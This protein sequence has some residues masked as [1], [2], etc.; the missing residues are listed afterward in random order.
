MSVPKT[1]R[2]KASLARPAIARG[3][4]RAAHRLAIDVR[5]ATSMAICW[6]RRP[7]EGN[8]STRN[9]LLTLIVVLTTFRRMSRQAAS[10][11]VDHHGQSTNPATS[12][13]APRPSYAFGPL[14]Q[15]EALL[16]IRRCRA[17]WRDRARLMS[18]FQRRYIIADR[19]APDFAGRHEPV[20]RG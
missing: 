7:L 5:P 1:W 18:N 3:D 11:A 4:R 13:K 15:G 10:F 6:L 16:F 12:C 8:P 20:G 17:A 2:R 9:F 19:A 14:R